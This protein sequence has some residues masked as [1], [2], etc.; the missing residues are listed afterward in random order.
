MRAV[1]RTRPPV[2]SL[3]AVEGQ[4]KG[5]RVVSSQ[6]ES[7]ER[8]QPFGTVSVASSTNHERN[9]SSSTKKRLRARDRTWP[10]R[11]LLTRKPSCRRIE[12]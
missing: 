4:G 10:W 3:C 5:L 12:T 8:L 2:R 11:G 9:P 7:R 6:F 1:R